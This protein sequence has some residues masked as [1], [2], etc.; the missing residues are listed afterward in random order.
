MNTSDSWPRSTVAL[1]A[2][3][4]TS[5]ST[6]IGSP[7]LSASAQM[8]RRTHA[9]ARMSTFVANTCLRCILAVR[10]ASSLNLG[11]E[12]MKNKFKTRKR[13]RQH[14]VVSVNKSLLL[15]S[16]ISVFINLKCSDPVGAVQRRTI[17]RLKVERPHLL[18]PLPL[19]ATCYHQHL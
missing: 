10:R 19:P 18:P 15:E 6:S 16:S 5:M 7:W 4:S 14:D 2:G 17:T 11:S 13:K 3:I 9:R 1:L 12:I 8:D